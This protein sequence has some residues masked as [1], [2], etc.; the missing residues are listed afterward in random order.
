[1]NITAQMNFPVVAPRGRANSDLSISRLRSS[2]YLDKN[3]SVLEADSASDSSNASDKKQ[4][5]RS[6]SL[7]SKAA[8]E[9]SKHLVTKEHFDEV[10]TRMKSEAEAETDERKRHFVRSVSHLIRTPMNAALS[11]LFI[12]ENEIMQGS[13]KALDTIRDVRFSCENAMGILNDYLTYEKIEGKRGLRLVKEVSGLVDL[14]RGLIEQFK[15]QAAYSHIALDLLLDIGD[16]AEVFVRVDAPHITQVFR[17]FLVNAMKYTPDYGHVKIQVS[18]LLDHKVRVEFKDSGAGI[19]PQHKASLFQDSSDEL[20]ASQGSGLGLY[21]SKRVVELHRGAI[22]SITPRDGRG[23]IFF[24]DLPMTSESPNSTP[25]SSFSTPSRPL[26]KKPR[27]LIVDDDALCRK[28]HNRL[29]SAH[30]ETC[31]EAPNGRDAV[32]IV[33]FSM[34]IGQPFDCI[35]MDSS[36]PVMSGP[37][38]STLI[39]EAGFTGKILGVTGNSLQSDID[40]FIRHGATEVIIKPLNPTLIQHIIREINM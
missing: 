6:G 33:K 19:A 8:E 34:A 16:R 21:V 10:I 4:H 28:M 39:R 29:F 2:N 14:L 24:V 36:M 26:D 18:C 7:T 11:A 30:C 3:A 1:M 5:Q 27:V 20:Q 40:D 13:P 22:G 15:M 31:T 35:I 12:V 25:S 38:A 23:S 17:N 9:V 32:S 37:E